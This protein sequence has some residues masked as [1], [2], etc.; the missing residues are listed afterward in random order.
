MKRFLR[1][2]ACCVLILSVVYVSLLFSPWKAALPGYHTVCYP[3]SKYP[4]ACLEFRKA[5]DSCSMKG[6]EKRAATLMRKGVQ[7]NLFNYWEGTRW[8]FNGTTQ[9]PGKGS[10]ACGYFV[11]TMLRDMGV[12]V[13]RVNYAKMASEKMIKK[14]V[15]EKNISRFSNIPLADFVKAIEKKGDQ[16]YV[17]GLDNHV[18]FL[19][20]E[21]KQVYF[22]HSSGRWPWA[23]VKE[24]AR[25]SIVLSKSKYRVA[26]CLTADDQ[27]MQRWLYAS[28]SVSR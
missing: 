8:N 26:G 17:L 10:I 12:P 27:F 16:V 24:N 20:C 9:T 1:F 5:L 11:T 23:V 19:V 25:K 15:A 21:N 6:D 14:L 7:E 18:G 2:C 4:A 13:Q 28:S 3:A 22:I